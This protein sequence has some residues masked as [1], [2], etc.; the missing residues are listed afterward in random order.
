MVRQAIA[1]KHKG[2]MNVFPT[3]TLQYV[4]PTGRA[5][6][7]GAGNYAP[8]WEAYFSSDNSMNVISAMALV[9]VM[10]TLLQAETL[11]YIFM[12]QLIRIVRSSSAMS[13]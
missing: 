1:T 6:T 2:L 11:V 13:R 10:V 8:E 3:L 9:I 5:A 12:A 7:D 4:R